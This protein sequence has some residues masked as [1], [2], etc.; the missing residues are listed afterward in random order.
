MSVMSVIQP[1]PTEPATRPRQAGSDL[2]AVRSEGWFDSAAAAYQTSKD[3][4]P[5]VQD[6]RLAEAYAPLYKTV[7]KAA[8]KSPVFGYF[9]AANEAMNLVPLWQSLDTRDRD[10]F[11]Q[12]VDALRKA[13]RLPA[14][15]PTDRAQFEGEVLSRNGQRAVDQIK[16]GQGSFTSR[17]VGGVAA[18]FNDPVQVGLA[19][20]TGGA[21]KGLSV[22]RSILVEGLLNSGAVAVE[23][24]QTITARARLGET[25]T[26]FDVAS[27]L[28]TAF[29]FGAVADLG[30]HGAGA[31]MKAGADA[32]AIPERTNPI[33]VAKAFAQA[34][35]EQLRTADQQ[36]ALNVIEREAS[37]LQTA[38]AGADAVAIDQHLARVDAAQRALVEEGE[39]AGAAGFARAVREQDGVGAQ[40]AF[41][42]KVRGAESGGN[43]AAQ[44][45]SSSAFG[46]YQFTKGTWEAYYVKRFGRDGLSSEQIAAKR[47]DP[48]LQEQL[49]RDLTAD[50]A[51]MLRKIG[52]PVTEANLYLTHLLGPSDAEKVLRASPDTPLEG[53]INAKSIAANR[54]FMEG[55]TAADIVAFAERKM[56]AE[57]GSGGGAL[58]AGTAPGADPSLAAVRP[59]V[60]LPDAVSGISPRIEALVPQLRALVNDPTIKLNQIDQLA[61]QLGAS[62][63]DIHA[64][65]AELVRGGELGQ[66]KDNGAYTRSRP[67][68]REESLIEW[69]KRTGGI[70]DGNGGEFKGGDFAAIGLN[71]GYKQGPF[72]DKAPIIQDSEFARQN[73]GADKVLRAAVNE[74]FF[75]ELQ[76]KL[77]AA[78]ADTLDTNDLLKAVDEEMRGRPR[79]RVGTTAWERQNKLRVDPNWKPTASEVPN[80]SEGR[81]F[82]QTMAQ[83]SDYAQEQLY[84][85]GTWL[86]IPME[87]VDPWILDRA[88]YIRHEIGVLDPVEAFDRA[89]NDYAAKNVAEALVATGD[90]SY[91]DISYDW[92]TYHDP[93][94]G[95]EGWATAPDRRRSAAAGSAAR[96]GGA[97]GGYSGSDGGEGGFRAEVGPLPDAVAER[98]SDPAGPEAKAQADAFT[99][100]LKAQVEAIDPN[101]ARKTAQEADIAAQQPLTG[102]RKTGVAQDPVMPEGL[103]GGPIEPGLF[104]DVPFET[105][106]A[107]PETAR[108]ALLRL[109]EEDAALKALR[110]CL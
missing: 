43:D 88:H 74:G 37:L 108:E 49:M 48:A 53:L 97:R 40:A 6:W 64:G 24:P 42:A 30:L 45:A 19:L 3:E 78:G 41:M 109:D 59:E 91:E 62:P 68:A 33:K 15:V 73:R 67:P 38:P 36:A 7:A 27:E 12:D 100:D 110:D 34:I 13:G 4:V 22:G 46:R 32:L 69:I 89:V 103:F 31:V 44:A 104:A 65:F 61:E 106:A 92:P 20:A 9:S 18:G 95:G 87:K 17:L 23:M 82:E 16:A 47:A 75:P 1:S 56:Q 76:G 2:D 94:R 90:K 58:I 63:E 11:W 71:D 101:I 5:A 70:Y 10:A 80:S 98:F 50:N 26:A 57:P 79:Y 60:D 28:G 25:T 105:G 8:G 54:S 35:P 66:R 102:A 86:G 51:A 96:E 52:A 39:R 99:H 55:R 93:E 84:F 72:R 77:D 107:V 14:G 85:H 83:F 81:T 29:A 21:S